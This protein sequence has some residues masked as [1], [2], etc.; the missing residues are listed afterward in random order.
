ME[1]FCSPTYR[2]KSSE[3]R[4]N[5][6]SSFSICISIIYFSFLTLW[7]KDPAEVCGIAVVKMSIPEWFQIVVEILPDFPPFNMTNVCLSYAPRL[8]WGIFILYS[9]FLRI[10]YFIKCHSSICWDHNL[11][12]I[13]QLVNVMMLLLLLCPFIPAINRFDPHD[14]HFWCAVGLDFLVLRWEIVHLWS[15]PHFH[16]VLFLF[17]VL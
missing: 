2:I 15:V 12:F 16:S 17:L 6:A 1:P 4:N 11:A 3:N 14:W 7:G 10:L 9:V 13:F 8:C 5:S